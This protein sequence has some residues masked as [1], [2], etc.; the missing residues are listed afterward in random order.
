MTACRIETV[1][2]VCCPS[3]EFDRGTDIDSTVLELNRSASG[4]GKTDAD[5]ATWSPVA[6]DPERLTNVVVTES[7]AAT[8]T[9]CGVDVEPAN[10][11]VPL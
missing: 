10:S 6:A 1:G 2:K 3:D 5:S 9:I 7:A 8:P 4:V 11:V